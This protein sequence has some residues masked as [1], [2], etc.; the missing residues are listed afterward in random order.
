VQRWQIGLK[1]SMQLARLLENLAAVE[2]FG[3]FVGTKSHENAVLAFGEESLSLQE[4]STD[5]LLE[6]HEVYLH[7]GTGTLVN[8]RLLET[9]SKM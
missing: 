5:Y 7:P 6:A 1:R 9:L 2:L 4:Q 8:K 3:Q